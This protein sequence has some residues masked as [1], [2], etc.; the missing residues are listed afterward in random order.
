MADIPQN[1][2]RANILQALKRIDQEGI[3]ADGRSSTY[4]VLFEGKRYPPKLAISYANGFAN[5]VD[6]DRSTFYSGENTPCWNLLR[7]EDFE[8]VKKEPSDVDTK[9]WLLSWNPDKWD[10]GGDGSAE[11]SV[12]LSVGNNV[13]WRCSSKQPAVG[14]NV[15][16]IRL[17]VSPKGI[18][19]KGS[20][21]KASFDAEDPNDASKK[22]NYIEFHVNELRETCAT[23]LLPSSLLKIAITE[24]N[25]SPQSSGISIKL[26]AVSTLDTLWEEGEDKASLQQFVDW[27][28]TDGNYRRVDWL[29]HYRATTMRIDELKKGAVEL[30]DDLLELIWKSGSN[31]IAG[32]KPGAL[33][34][35][36]YNSNKAFLYEKTFQILTNP[37]AEV[38][39][40]VYAD[41]TSLKDQGDMRQVYR[42]V[43]RRV[44]SGVSPELYTTILS[45]NKCKKLLTILEND[46]QLTSDRSGD[47]FALN[48]EIRRCMVEAGLDANRPH[49]NNIAM[50]QL[51]AGAVDQ[52]KHKAVKGS[53]LEDEMTVPDS[54]ECIRIMPA[55][56]QILYGPPGTGKTYHTV[57]A[58]LSI[59][60]PELSL[61]E[62]D[63]STMKNK[64]D[65]YVK[66][67]RIHFVTFHQ[68]FSYEDFVEGLR[69]SSVEGAISY[70]VEP[71]VFKTACVRAG[72]GG[73]EKIDAFD[74]AIVSLV[75][76][77]DQLD[78]RL[79][80]ATVRGKLFSIEFTGGPTFKVFPESTENENPNYVASIDNVRKLY[81]TGS[82]KG[83]Y[84]SSY[85][86]GLLIFLKKELGLPE[87][88]ESSNETANDEP[89]V[90][91][92][93]EINRGNISSIFGELITLIEPSKRA[94]EEEALSVTLPY[95]KESFQV[96]DNLYLIGTMNTADRSLA[97]MDTALRRRFDFVEMMPDV[98]VLNDLTVDGIDIAAMLTMMNRRIEVLYDR[99]HTLGHA[100][101]MPLLD[102]EG[103][104]GS[105]AVL[106]N[107]FANKILPLLE[108]YFFEDWEKIRLV[109]GD[110]QKKDRQDQFVTENQEGF[111]SADLFGADTGLDYEVEEAKSYSRNDT[112]L[113]RV[114]S[115][116][117]IYEH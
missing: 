43:I 29:D 53:I 105:L 116:V 38:A 19:A 32:V 28:G 1:I 44:F 41:W 21:V 74:Q 46:F 23:G 3:P 71:G 60:E 81:L 79:K 17:G 45:V 9:T 31:G 96:P 55:L 77:C 92:I 103:A 117:G 86:E 97:L 95:S 62:I 104:E 115:Y 59:L 80:L 14:D 66:K 37:S 20:V 88:D 50:W 56:N 65:S 27:S 5:G 82:K 7:K 40:Q 90:L 78:G 10:A 16:L 67:G 6:L 75:D 89:V 106:Q 36:D 11:G 22:R 33:S 48:A 35:E 108:E 4:D 113:T 18:I 84:N 107:I 57:N 94:G 98:K 73:G 70:N 15:Y 12:G 69:A 109:L 58:A 51:Y 49:Q 47:W 114:S 13:S 112:A 26:S 25:W 93:D 83:T 99:E 8:I 30:D 42:A 85:V 72:A 101:F 87:Y 34:N 2:T 111:N 76:H 64:F 54:E 24:Q 68:S 102:F 110:N 52:E 91:I 100:F 61:G 63:R 39:R